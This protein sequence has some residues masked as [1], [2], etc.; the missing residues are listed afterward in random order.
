MTG[1]GKD[2]W[3]PAGINREMTMMDMVATTV[4]ETSSEVV[5]WDQVALEVC[6]VTDRATH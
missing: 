5:H 1:T 3:V 6:T 2:N 4:W